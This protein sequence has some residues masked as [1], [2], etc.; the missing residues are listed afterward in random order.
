[1]TA[2]QRSIDER[3][4]ARAD[5]SGFVPFDRFM[6]EALY[7]PGAGFYARARSPLGP[8]GDFYTA[9]HVHPMYARTLAHR[10]RQAIDQ[11]PIGRPVVIAEVGPGDGRLAAGMLREFRA[12]PPARAD[13]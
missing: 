13:W 8:R 4:R 7:A 2:A 12:R 3:L 6:E 9:A 1:M 5:P 11:L 10:V